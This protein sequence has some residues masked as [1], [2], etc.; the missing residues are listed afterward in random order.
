MDQSWDAI[1]NIN[2]VMD[3]FYITNNQ[4]LLESTNELT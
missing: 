2:Q 4:L 1:K 3:N